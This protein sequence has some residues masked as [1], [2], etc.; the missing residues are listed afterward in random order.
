MPQS[1][2]TRPADP[3][4]SVES[5]E[6]LDK[7]DIENSAIPPEDDPAEWVYPKDQSE[8]DALRDLAEQIVQ[9][10]EALSNILGDATIGETPVSELLRQICA[11]QGTTGSKFK[12]AESSPPPKPWLA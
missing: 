10:D 11:W 9:H 5:F 12:Q 7:P 6:I 4:Y 1:R 2:S 8:D 3:Q